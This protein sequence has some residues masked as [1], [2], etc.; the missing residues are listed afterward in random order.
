MNAWSPSV[1]NVWGGGPGS[2]G[3]FGG[4]QLPGSSQSVGPPASPFIGLDRQLTYRPTSRTLNQVLSQPH[5]GRWQAGEQYAQELYGSPGQRAFPTPFGDRF[6]DA[7][8]NLPG[9][10]VLA[11]EVKTY[12][13]WTTING[14][15]QRQTVPA[16][17]H[18]RWQILKD[19]VLRHRDPTHDPRWEFLGAP[20]SPELADLLRRRRIVFIYE[21]Q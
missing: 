17:P 7:P 4:G 11:L 19:I 16:T 3:G 5:P 10:G 12:G 1:L 6:P 18:I 13:R 2:T 15:A 20:P 9:G 8:V 21:P 14:T